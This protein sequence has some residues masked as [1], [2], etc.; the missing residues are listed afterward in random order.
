MTLRSIPDLCPWAYRYANICSWVAGLILSIDRQTGIHSFRPQTT[1]GPSK[2]M[3]L[4]A[5]D[6]CS[7]GVVAPWFSRLKDIM[8]P[9]AYFPGMGAALRSVTAASFLEQ[10]SFACA[11]L[12]A[13]LILASRL[14]AECGS[15]FSCCRPTSAHS[16][17]SKMSL[18]L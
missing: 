12:H 10:S 6:H 13:S 17:A 7:S 11:S 9:T 14:N 2:P 5:V 18:L 15:I 3:I 1:L 4:V 16:S 8:S